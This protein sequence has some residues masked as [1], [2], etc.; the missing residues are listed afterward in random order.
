MAKQTGI[1]KIKGTI[2]G[3]TFY[4]LEKEYYARKKSSLTGRRVKK[5][6]VFR[7]TMRYARLLAKASVIGSTVYHSIPKEKKRRELYQKITG[8]A[9][10]LLKDGNNEELIRTSLTSVFNPLP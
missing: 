10:Q 3:I 5:D 6:P 9:I 7:E 2:N 4:R 1:L 8:Q